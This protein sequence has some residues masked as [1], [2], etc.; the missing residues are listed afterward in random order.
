MRSTH[1]DILFE[2]LRIGPVTAKNRF[3]QVPHCN[4][5]GH[6]APSGMAAMRRV[7]AEGGWAVVCTEVCEIH[8]SADVSPHSHARLWDDSDIPALARAAE[9]IHQHD[10]LAGVELGHHGF[11][12][13][14][15][16]SREIPMGPSSHTVVSYDPVQ[17]R[18]MDKEDI[19]NLRRWHVA[20]ARRA[21][22]AGFDIIYVYAAHGLVTPM[23]FLSKR[24][25]QR[26]DE[27]GGSLENRVRLLR[28][29]IE[30]TKSAVGDT[31]AVPVRICVDEL[32]G[33]AGLCSNGEGRDVIEML[34]D[35]PD[36]WDLTVGDWSNDSRPS[37][38]GDEG[39]HEQ[40]VSF[41]KQVT[42][43]PVVGNGRFTS[44]DTMVSQIRRGVLDFIGAA[45][46]SIADPFLPRKVEEGRMGDIREC[47]GCNI[48][49][50]A[51]NTYTPI[52]C[53]QNPTMGEEWRRGW[54][55]EHIPE[56]ESEDQVLV[57]G[58]G[59]AG[60][61]CAVSLG[62]RGYDVL[63]AEGSN[64]LGGR[65][66]REP[67]L[68]GLAI[69]G[70]VREYR[71]EQLNQLPNVQVFL[72]SM[73]T[74]QD[75]LDTGANR[76]VIAAGSHWRRD[77][78]ARYHRAPISELDQAAVF[79]PDDVMN[80]KTIEGPVIVYDDDHY[81]MGGVIA[82]KLR[83]DGLDVTLVT[84]APLV[85]AWTVNTLEQPRIQRRLLEIG[86][87]IRANE[88]LVAFRGGEATLACAFTDTRQTLKARSVVMVTARLQ[89][90][91]L[92]DDLL[93]RSSEWPA[94]GIKTVDRIG[95]AVAPGA[96]AAAVF[97]GHRYA[98]ELDQTPCGDD[99]P[100]R[101]ENPELGSWP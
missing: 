48:C 40:Y 27:Y 19:R 63:L 58:A 11:R 9:A 7:K 49:A 95:D 90:S 100:F 62:K 44:P 22:R 76:I 35:L 59:P 86:V 94:A 12:A 71:V 82:E 17:S 53:T 23:Q 14:N 46:P 25:N 26:T 99:V 85:S 21:K 6:R 52:R 74:A 68:P 29:L 47:I 70:R 81:Y 60:L 78:V 79:T 2:P 80:G 91:T 30:E 51:D 37:R 45:R 101:R 69:W 15:R 42:G 66:A 73:M 67:R 55:P 75:V 34:A 24:Y 65:S 77:G 88:A 56:R 64:E 96:I 50:A 39:A 61:E 72:A 8:P 28:E 84:P 13:Q 54:H 3:Y 97:S 33:P 4:G 10:A 31:C 87:H 18:V 43:K 20:A 5:M 41:V 89:N 83:S 38:F 36:L 93:A 32:V 57:V 98:R 1:Y 92:Y 16:T